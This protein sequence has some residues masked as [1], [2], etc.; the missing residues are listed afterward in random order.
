MK[1]SDEFGTQIG[2]NPPQGDRSADHVHGM[3]NCYKSF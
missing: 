1:P 3:L 2:L